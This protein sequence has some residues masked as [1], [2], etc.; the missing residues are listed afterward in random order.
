V[1]HDSRPWHHGPFYERRSHRL[2]SRSLFPL[3]NRHL[4]ADDI[5]G[6][7]GYYMGLLHYFWQKLRAT[8]RA[9]SRTHHPRVVTTN[10]E[11]CLIVIYC[12]L[13]ATWTGQTSPICPISGASWFVVSRWVRLSVVGFAELRKPQVVRSIRVD[14][15]FSEDW[16]SGHR[17]CA[18]QAPRETNTS[19][20]ALTLL[21]F[22]GHPVKPPPSSYRI[23][24]G[25]VFSPSLLGVN[26]MMV[27]RYFVMLARERFW[28][29]V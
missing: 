25:N 26:W 13:A 24:P 14:G 28:E 17:Q 1:L 5:G 11:P 8:P 22:R 4:S 27:A 10:L 2:Q 21:R 7:G 19:R 6:L 18:S 3:K 29:S 15:W 16:L 23:W 9:I 12:Y 20:A